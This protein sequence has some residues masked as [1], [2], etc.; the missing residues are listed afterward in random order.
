MKRLSITNDC[1]DTSLS[2][3]TSRSALVP[4]CFDPFLRFLCATT[5]SALRGQISYLELRPRDLSSV[6]A[7]ERDFRHR[8]TDMD[9]LSELDDGA[10]YAEGG[11]S[12]EVP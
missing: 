3:C 6:P 7:V 9:Q 11:V 1:I 12:H 4:D 8:I 10:G 5:S 2:L